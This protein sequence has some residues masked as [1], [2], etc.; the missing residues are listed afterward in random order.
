MKDL[1]KIRDIYRAIAE[2]ETQFMLQYNLSLNEGML[3]CALLDHPRLTSGEIAEALGLTHSNTSKLIRS[4]EEKKLVA[5]IVGKVDKRQMHFSLTSEGK[6]Q[7]DAIK[8]TSH[9]MPA[10]LQ[11]VVSMLEGSES[12]VQIFPSSPSK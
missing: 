12:S 5:R 2:F 9:E 7:I 1:C 6:Q 8:N 11:R 10:I 4:V 3:L